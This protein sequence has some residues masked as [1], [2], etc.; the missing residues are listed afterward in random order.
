[1][2][3]VSKKFQINTQ[4]SILYFIYPLLQ[5]GWNHSREKNKLLQRKKRIKKSKSWAIREDHISILR[6]KGWFWLLRC[7]N[8]R[9]SVQKDEIIQWML[10]LYPLTNWKAYLWISFTLN[11]QVGQKS[12]IWNLESEKRESQR[13]YR[14]FPGINFTNILRAAFTPADPKCAKWLVNSSSFLQLQDLQV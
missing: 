14:G 11:P 2:Q 9:E 3:N 5:I 12:R 7:L 8:L 6:A 1:M 13:G 4:P 10:R